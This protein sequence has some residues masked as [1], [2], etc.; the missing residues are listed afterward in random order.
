MLHINGLK[1]ILRSRLLISQYL[2][3][4]NSCVLIEFALFPG[5]SR[6]YVD[7]IELYY[8]L[9]IIW[10]EQ[11][12]VLLVKL[13]LPNVILSTWVDLILL[14]L[15]QELWVSC[16][17]HLFNDELFARVSNRS[18]CKKPCSMQHVI[19]LILKLEKPLV[20]FLISLE[21]CFQLLN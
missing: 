20:F 11:L 18:A 6:F 5:L 14:K 7:L 4:H 3:I 1:N 2:Y 17:P 16:L 10:F 19:R 21:M 13:P 12:L 15:R 8:L 9:L